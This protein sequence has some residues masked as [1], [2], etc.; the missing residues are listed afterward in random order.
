MVLFDIFSGKLSILLNLLALKV[1][2]VLSH[3]ADLEGVTSGLET[4]LTAAEENIQ[5]TY[6]I[7]LWQRKIV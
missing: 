6:Y 3:F 5:G 1:V 4:R 7:D 2:H